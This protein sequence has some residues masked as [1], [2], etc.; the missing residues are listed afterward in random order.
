MDLDYIYQKYELHHSNIILCGDFNLHHPE[1]SLINTT[2]YPKNDLKEYEL[3]VKV[4]MKYNLNIINKPNV[5]TY[6]NN[7][8]HSQNKS[9]LDL[10]IISTGLKNNYYDWNI[11]PLK[12]SDHVP[13]LLQFYNPI[14][15]FGSI[16]NNN[17]HKKI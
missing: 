4:M 15:N 6:I 2:N 1:M 9:V 3:L 14:K 13:I 8:Q 17:Q 5:P 10:S 11:I 16:H 12:G 7:N